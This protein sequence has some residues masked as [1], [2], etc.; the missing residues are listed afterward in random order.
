MRLST[1]EIVSAS[2]PLLCRTHLVE[3][4]SE[5]IEDA[6]LVRRLTEWR[7]AVGG[8]DALQLRLK[9]IGKDEP[10]SILSPL[11]WEG[12]F[13]SWFEQFEL[14]NDASRHSS[15][16]V[17]P[18]L[19]FASIVEPFVCAGMH[20][21]QIP[22]CLAYVSATAIEQARKNL[23]KRLS[24][25]AAPCYLLEFRAQHPAATTGIGRIDERRS[26]RA[27]VSF[28]NDAL[29][30]GGWTELYSTYPTLARLLSSVSSQWARSLSLMLLELSA[31]REVLEKTFGISKNSLV[32]SI[33]TDLSDAHEGGRTVTRVRFNTGR[34]LYYKPRPLGLESAL[35]DVFCLLSPSLRTDHQKL[36]KTLTVENHGWMAEVPYAPLKKKN[37]VAYYERFGEMIAAAFALCGTD[38]HFEN[39]IAS[40]D[41][42]VIIDAEA[43]IYP[44]FSRLEDFSLGRAYTVATNLKLIDSVLSLGALPRWEISEGYAFDM[45]A[46][47]A[48]EDATLPGV[49][50]RW[51]N[52]DCDLVEARKEPSRLARG[53]SIPR[54][55][56]GVAI[57]IETF[58]DAVEIGFRRG[59]RAIS[60]NKQQILDLLHSQS[61]CG[62]FLLRHTNTYSLLIQEL[63]HPSMM[64]DSLDRSIA[65]ERLAKP[66]LQFEE[67]RPHASVL[68]AE[69]LAL[70][71]E[72]IP[73]FET[74]P[75][76][77]SI[78]LGD[79]EL[80][81]C[82]FAKTGMESVEKR[83]ASAN[84]GV[85][86]QA[87]LIR[88]S[89]DARRSVHPSEKIEKNLELQTSRI[90]NATHQGYDDLDS[91]LVDQSISIGRT[92]VESAITADDGGAAWL[93]FTFDFSTK[94]YVFSPL[95]AG[96]YDGVPG[97]AVFLSGLARKTGKKEFSDLA[98]SALRPLRQLITDSK[99][100]NAV[101]L[102]VS[103]G[104]P[105]MCLALMI[106]S[107]LLSAEILLDEAED[108]A[109]RTFPTDCQDMAVTDLLGGAPGILSVGTKLLSRREFSR[110]GPRIEEFSGDLLSRLPAAFGQES[111]QNISFAHGLWGAISAVS[112]YSRICNKELPDLLSKLEGRTFSV[113]STVASSPQWCS[114]RAGILQALISHSPLG[115]NQENLVRQCAEDLLNDSRC[116]FHHVCC[117]KIGCAESIADAAFALKCSS[118]RA[119]AHEQSMLVLD[120]VHDAAGWKLPL[121]GSPEKFNP[122]F[123]Q[124][125]SGIGYALLRISDPASLPSVLSL[126]VR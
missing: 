105:G 7:N 5:V 70:E 103:T 96:L 111:R 63:H 112:S 12:K 98:W 75:A 124:G 29:S 43:F 102:S 108:L 31:D 19:P 26:D 25:L 81:S 126:G 27:L 16:E 104:V 47:G 95:K 22:K 57:P 78:W 56:L 84:T 117:G 100:V 48:T 23:K 42:P 10:Y 97:I 67:L 107:E 8:S 114:G 1:L 21:L 58:G 120:E 83:I 89:I 37:S 60:R 52:T 74:R 49:T 61:L 68:H 94:R 116:R 73:K 90:E 77:R 122:G 41:Q 50:Y 66:F 93:G 36:P 51:H 88:V 110:L 64:R 34:S 30:S 119:R 6:S 101:G 71:D 59:I 76:S 44:A 121:S 65:L 38:L 18:K 45:S 62:R 40:G 11:K 17:D 86:E 69:I 85:D 99:F 20:R 91:R 35:N 14:A 118:L 24:R 115:G 2:T 87:Q 9:Q 15:I 79:K 3:G 46:G 13:P 80:G 109:L 28:M 55:E 53:Q 106:C 125:L 123:F 72:N 82:F 4:N 54:S 92:I 39:I 33:D 113:A 32:V